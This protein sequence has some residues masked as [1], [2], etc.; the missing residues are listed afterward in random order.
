MSRFQEIKPILG[1]NP[2]KISIS[3]SEIQ[4]FKS[5]RRRWYLNYYLGLQ[6]KEKTHIGPLTLGSRLHN[7]LEN[8][9]NDETG[10]L[11]LVDEY[12]RLQRIDAKAFRNS[13]EFDDADAVKKFQEE[14]ELGRIMMEGYLEWL[15]EEDVDSDIEFVSQEEQLRYTL[16]HDDRVEIIGKI[17]ARVKRRSDGSLA[18]LDFKSAA[19]SNFTNYLKYVAFSEQL[20]H[21][22]L[23]E[24]LTNPGQRVDGGRYRVLKK[25]KR[26]SSAKPPF[27]LDVD[28]RFNKKEMKSFWMRL[29]GTLKDLMAVRDGL[30]SGED[31]RFLAYPT[32]KM[33]W[34]CGTCPFSKMC[35]M[36]DDGSDFEGYAMANYQQFDPNDRYNDKE[37]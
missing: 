28:I 14:S 32:Q 37:K 29:M 9:Y 12:N 16:P 4:T 21:Y 15:D 26:S 7:A 10:K 1:I 23:L 17:D 6:E 11:D 31:D 33:D 22:N 3:N 25:V 20:K 2:D 30:D 13:K 5:C 27:Y 36:M 8:Y 19:S 34:V 24:M 35:V 18:D